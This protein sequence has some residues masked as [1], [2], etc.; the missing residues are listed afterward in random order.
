MD[1]T[2]CVCHAGSSSWAVARPDWRRRGSPTLRGHRVTL[3]ERSSRL[4]GLAAV[5]G[6]NGPLVEWLASEVER[7]GVD[8]RIRRQS[9]PTD[10]D[11]VVQCTGS[12]PGRPDHAVASDA[13]VLDVA[14]LRLG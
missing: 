10:A 12:Q 6:P 13:V 7:L 3:V 5:A 9:L 2:G 11:V 8:V 14:A 4:G 1:A